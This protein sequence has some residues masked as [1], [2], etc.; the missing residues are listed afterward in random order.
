[1]TVV[2]PRFSSVNPPSSRYVRQRHFGKR[3]PSGADHEKQRLRLVG[4][5]AAHGR[6]PIAKLDLSEIHRCDELSG[7]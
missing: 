1:L 7:L 4:L 2:D 5:N 3:R 6:E